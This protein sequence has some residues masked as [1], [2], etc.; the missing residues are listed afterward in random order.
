[1][2]LLRLTDSEGKPV[3][4]NP[5][6][7]IT[8]RPNHEWEDDTFA[9]KGTRIE[10]DGAVENVTETASVVVEALGSL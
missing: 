1:M 6:K 5:S 9:E 2:K 10:L 4:I 8:I 7:V 3:Y